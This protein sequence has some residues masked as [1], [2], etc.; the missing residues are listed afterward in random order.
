[1]E[2]YRIFDTKQMSDIGGTLREWFF[3]WKVFVYVYVF[4]SRMGKD[5]LCMR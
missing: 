4:F 5:R 2:E 3:R 1:M